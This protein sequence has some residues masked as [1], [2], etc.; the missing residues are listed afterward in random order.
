M[1]R[2]KKLKKVSLFTSIFHTREACI[3]TFDSGIVP[4]KKQKG[5]NERKKKK[6]TIMN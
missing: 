3:Q 4:L 1:K 6:Y 2:K 5:N